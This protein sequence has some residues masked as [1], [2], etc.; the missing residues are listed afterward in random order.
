MVL[1]SKHLYPG[2]CQGR[3]L[4]VSLCLCVWIVLAG[5]LI[6]PCRVGFWQRQK[7]CA[8]GLLT[9][10]MFT[11]PELCPEMISWQGERTA[12]LT[13]RS[14]QWKAPCEIHVKLKL[15]CQKGTNIKLLCFTVSASQ[16]C[17]LCIY[18]V[19][20]TVIEYRSIFPS[21]PTRTK[22]AHSGKH[23]IFLKYVGNVS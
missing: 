7:S 21:S 8:V 3:L 22:L 14:R 10:Q 6:V 23:L 9:L 1:Q 12:Q 15:H 13:V 4:Y 17:P 2:T 11:I 16:K 20:W 18:F 19:F 5:L